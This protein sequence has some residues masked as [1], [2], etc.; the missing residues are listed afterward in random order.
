MYG[1]AGRDVA[2]KTAENAAQGKHYELLK[3]LRRK[4]LCHVDT[5]AITWIVVYDDVQILQWCYDNGCTF[6][7]TVL[8][9][10]VAAG[11]IATA[12]WLKQ[13]GV[14]VT[15]QALVVAAGTRAF[16]LCRMDD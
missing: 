4:H 8:L 1:S 10:G 5:R 12:K 6:D 7:N 14:P 9:N 16:E 13:N 2:R 11:S 3:W 15:H